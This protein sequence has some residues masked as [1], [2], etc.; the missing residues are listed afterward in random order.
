MLLAWPAEG[1]TRAAEQIC[2]LHNT[3]D[4]AAVWCLLTAHHVDKS[5]VITEASEI[6][7]AVVLGCIC[8]NDV[9]L[10]QVA[11]PLLETE[12]D[13]TMLLCASMPCPLPVHVLGCASLTLILSPS[14][15]VLVAI[16]LFDVR[17]SLATYVRDDSMLCTQCCLHARELMQMLYGS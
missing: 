14:K 15:H 8:P 13:F 7:F 9:L 10:L 5:K 16:L 2:G 11:G 4:M 12:I 6:C 1:M 17:C 3:G